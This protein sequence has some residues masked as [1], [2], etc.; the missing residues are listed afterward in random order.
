MTDEQHGAEPERVVPPPPMNAAGDAATQF[1]PVVPLAPPLSPPSPAGP[2]PPLPPYAAGMPPAPPYGAGMPPAAPYAAGMPPGPPYAAGM[3]P[4]PAAGYPAAG[5][6]AAAQ[7]ASSSKVLGIV[8]AVVGAVVVL[9]VVGVA[10]LIGLLTA[11]PDEASPPPAPTSTSQAE[12]PG[13]PSED[14][15]SDGDATGIAE[16]LDAKIDEY[17]RLRDSGALWEKIPDS[18]YNRTAVSAFLYL[19]TDMKVATIWGVDEQQ[20]QEY[21]QRM[22]MLEERLLAQEPLGDDIKITLEDK[23]FTYDGETGE[24]G[25]TDK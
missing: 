23:I 17:K 18:E 2:N 3:P 24:G 19:M 9:A 5:Y 25:Y 22:A 11:S 1:P 16:R 7:P 20:A 10:T 4:G 13:A 14:P 12:E 21:D 8:L 15:P 6:P